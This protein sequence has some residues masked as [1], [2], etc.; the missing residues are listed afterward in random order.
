MG[1]IE[2]RCVLVDGV[3]NDEAAARCARRGDDGG[4][5]V[6]Q[7]LGAKPLALQT[8]IERQLG[9]KDC[10]DALRRP[11]PDTRGR[12]TPLK[13]MRGEGKV[14]DNGASSFLDEQIRAGSLPSRAPRVLAQPAVEGV[15]PTVE[16]MKIVPSGKR[17]DAVAH[18]GLI[19]LRRPVS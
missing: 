6:N 19:R 3:D 2:A 17:L 8:R 4:Q 15:V 1:A 12:V 7:Q 13:E 10:G 14:A 9:E 18:V 11:A 16:S 5:S